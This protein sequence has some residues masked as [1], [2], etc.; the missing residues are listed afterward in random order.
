MD[1]TQNGFKKKQDSTIYYM[2]E[3]NAI[4]KDTD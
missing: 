3:T 4:Y 1:K 2:E